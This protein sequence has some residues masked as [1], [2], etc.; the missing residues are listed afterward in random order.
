MKVFAFTDKRYEVATHGVVG[1][2]AFVF[3]S[4]PWYARDVFPQLLAGYGFM[5][6]DLHGQPGSVYLYSGPAAELAALHVDTVRA[7]QLGGAVVFVTSCYLPQTPFLQAFMSAGAS[8]VIAGEGENF[9]QLTRLSG[10]QV[11]A[12]R[13]LELLQA[14]TALTDALAQSKNEL[15]QNVIANLTDRRATQDTLAFALYQPQGDTWLKLV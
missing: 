15:R 12:K 4:G 1:Y 3:T 9:G 2:E 10:A 6:F 7:A 5:Y 13:L 8:A 14:G 11:L